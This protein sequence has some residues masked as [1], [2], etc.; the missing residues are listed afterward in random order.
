MHIDF[1]NLWERLPKAPVRFLG[2]GLIGMWS[3][4]MYLHPAVAFPNLP[5]DSRTAFDLALIAVMAIAAILARFLPGFAPLVGQRWAPPCALALL[6]ASTS[7]NFGAAILGSAPS[8]IMQAALIMGGIGAA[9][10]MLLTSEFFGL[11]HPK[12]TILYM[13]LGW[14]AG[15]VSAVFLRA[16]PLPYLW[17]SMTAIPVVML[18]CLWRS[19]ASLSAS[20]LSLT[21]SSRFSFPLLPLIPIVLCAVVKRGLNA[22]APLE[23]NTEAINDAGMIAAALIVLAGLTLR[24]GNLNMRTLWKL[25]VCLMTISV[26]AFTMAVQDWSSEAVFAA[27]LGMA[28]L[29]TTAYYLLFL[30]MTA[31][32]ANISYRWGVCALWLFAIENATHLLAGTGA[33][34]GTEWLMRIA[35]AETVI[36]DTAFAVFAVAAMMVIAL[37]F[38]RFSPDS[39]WGLSIG[40]EEAFG[41][42]ER[43]RCL[44]ERLIDE[45]GLTQREGEVLFMCMQG[46]RPAT[47]AEELFVGVSTVRTH[48][49]HFY[50]KLGVHSRKELMEL[51]GARRAQ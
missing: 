45:G 8:A 13:S 39:L 35:G 17:I 6:L 25:G 7:I 27:G 44:C 1:E 46:K 18:L 15:M 19:Y 3:N 36:W 5:E 30:L 34:A 28:V 21:P 32:L 43:L 41:E 47:I 10:M 11:I 2:W 51:I 38:R 23:F 4:V 29:S 16:L 40:D 50:A 12:R 33:M 31:I 20:E 26:A 42:S 49:K 14:L 9:I 48:I 22:L 24:G 37:L